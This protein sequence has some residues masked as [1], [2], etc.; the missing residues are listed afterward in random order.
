MSSWRVICEKMRTREPCARSLGSS[1]CSSIIF[2]AL[3]QMCGP[4]TDESERDRRWCVGRR[5]AHA[6]RRSRADDGAATTIR[7]GGGWSRTTREGVERST[8]RA[9]RRGRDSHRH[10]A[11]TLPNHHEIPSRAR[12]LFRRTC[13]RRLA[14]EELTKDLEGK[15]T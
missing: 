9:R 10:T 8:A 6:H 15:Q 7:G 1:F 13:R 14:D 5:G 12:S 3:S 11:A 4:F 2:P